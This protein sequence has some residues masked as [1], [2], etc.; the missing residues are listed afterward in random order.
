GGCFKTRIDKVRPDGTARTQ[1]SDGGPSCTL[2]GK[3]QCGDADPGFSADGRTIYSSRGFPVAPSGAPPSFTERKL[4]AFSSDAW[5]AGKPEQ[6]L[7][8]PS[9]PSCIEGVP[10]ESAD[11]RRILLFRACFDGTSS[12]PGVYLSDPAGSYRT[13]V[14]DGFG[15]DWNPA[16]R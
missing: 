14:A 9:Q 5:Y 11:G 6:D 4:Y 16:A 3:E 13:F 2:P 15:P 1:V 7:S 12:T 10:K 8:L